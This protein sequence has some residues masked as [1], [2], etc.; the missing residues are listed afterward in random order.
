MLHSPKTHPFP[1]L[2]IGIGVLLLIGTQATGSPS[3][4]D[5]LGAIVVLI[6]DHR[7]AIDDFTELVVTVEGA[8]LHRRGA[9]FDRGWTAITMGP[10]EIDL[11][12]YKDGTTF[13]LGRKQIPTGRYDAAEL[14][15]SSAHGVVQNGDRVGVPLELKR[16]RLA[17][18]IRVGYLTQVTFDLVV[19]DLRDHPEKTWSVLIEEVRVE[20]SVVDHSSSDPTPEN[21]AGD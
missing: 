13:E 15:A 19:Q 3:D 18:D 21:S 9:S 2:L 12:L 8:R 16:V 20:R 4:E 14:I 5:N 6:T 7:D 1:Q 17:A 10:H 11:T